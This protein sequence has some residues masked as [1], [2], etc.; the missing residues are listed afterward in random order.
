MYDA[1]VTTYMFGRIFI[2]VDIL[3]SKESSM[4]S[5]QESMSILV[6]IVVL[7]S[8]LTNSVV[9]RFRTLDIFNLRCEKNARSK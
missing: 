1:Y 2:V 5:C 7:T 4:K 3:S 6:S 9:K 8:L